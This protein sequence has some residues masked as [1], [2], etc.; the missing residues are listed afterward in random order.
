MQES[1]KTVSVFAPASIGNVSV[2]FD[3]LGLAIK[4]IDGSL[5]GDV[6]S[7]SETNHA[8]SSLVV[9]G[10]FADKLPNNKEDNIV[11]S[12]LQLFNENLVAHQHS[13]LVIAMILDK[14]MPVGSV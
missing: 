3:L 8:E 14:K 6:V 11:W 13:A 7:V 12:C 10:D 1:N 9:I 4:P 5:L 2:G